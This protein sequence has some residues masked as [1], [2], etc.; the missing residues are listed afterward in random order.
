MSK[1][2]RSA[3]GSEGT[4]GPGAGERAP[5]KAAG[6]AAEMGFDPVTRPDGGPTLASEEQREFHATHFTAD[7]RGAAMGGA[8]P[9]GR[10]RKVRGGTPPAATPTDG[11]STQ[12]KRRGGAGPK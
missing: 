4:S 3:T 1:V 5:A 8:A 9:G 2:T 6:H 11:S 10:R 12:P 7:P